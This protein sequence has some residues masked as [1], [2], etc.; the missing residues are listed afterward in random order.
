MSFLTPSPVAS[1]GPR[2]WGGVVA[3]GAGA[4][5][6]ASRRDCW[7]AAAVPCACL[8]LIALPLCW[9][10]V[11]RASP[12]L[13]DWL[14]P[15]ATRWYAVG[16]HALVRWAAA[17]LGVYVGFWLAWLL[18]PPLSAPA[19]EHLVR[20]QESA[21]GAPPRPRRGLWFELWCGLEAQAGALLVALPLWLLYW[22][23]GALLPGAALLLLP[24]QWLP[25]ALGLAWSLLDYPLTLRGV[26]LRARA[27]L[28]MAH[29]AAIL[30]FGASFALATL[31]PGMA[32][33]LLPA[34]V[35]GATRLAVRLLPE[36]AEH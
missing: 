7:F 12:W 17:A 36:A 2:P 19:L 25:L 30:G 27:R 18:A 6:L 35:V 14:M 11:S 31:I 33:L 15:E 26:G 8:G 24:L 3:L 10:A 29:P 16:A 28:L 13:A 4:R 5:F 20:V 32:L 21:L 23:L 9:L 34:G 1:R 22:V